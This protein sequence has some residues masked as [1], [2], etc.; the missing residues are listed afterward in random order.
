MV[1]LNG[2]FQVG[3]GASGEPSPPSRHR[4]PDQD[5]AGGQGCWSWCDLYLLALAVLLKEQ[6]T[7]KKAS[8]VDG[9]D[10]TVLRC[11]CGEAG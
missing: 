6:P 9:F 1:I 4:G 2:F 7:W 5:A 10:L 11:L 3:R 8:A